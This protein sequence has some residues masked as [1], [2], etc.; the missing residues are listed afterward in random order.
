[1]NL[2]LQELCHGG[3]GQGMQVLPGTVADVDFTAHGKQPGLQLSHLVTGRRV[4]H[5]EDR[6]GLAKVAGTNAIKLRVKTCETPG[7]L[8]FWPSFT[9]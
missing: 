4:E 8:S 2:M 6:D 9:P 5:H 1:M 3:A 7:F